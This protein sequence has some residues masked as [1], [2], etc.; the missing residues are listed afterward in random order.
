MSIEKGMDKNKCVCVYIYKI[1]IDT[2]IYTSIHTCIHI[3]I[4]VLYINIIKIYV[5]IYTY[6][7]NGILAVKNG[8]L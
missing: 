8:I 5:Y 7:H 2:C 1:N 6:T 3:L 4:Y